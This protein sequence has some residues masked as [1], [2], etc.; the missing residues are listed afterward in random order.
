MHA[1]VRDWSSAPE[2]L[3]VKEVAKLVRLTENAVYGAIRAGFIPAANF[4]D[5]CTRVSKTAL[6]KAMEGNP[7]HQGCANAFSLP[8][9]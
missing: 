1:N 8:G 4:G 6:M 9:E 5:R 2:V 3:T 7:S